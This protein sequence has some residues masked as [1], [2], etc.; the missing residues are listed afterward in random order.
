V[1]LFAA[2]WWLSARPRPRGA[3]SG[4]FLI[5]YGLVRFVVEY[6][7]EPDHFLG[8]L[9]L[10]LS[11]GQWLSAPMVLLGAGMMLWAYRAP[12]TEATAAKRR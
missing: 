6:T 4:A 8:V 7:R 11:M 1:A 2:L 12:K 5:G 10:G 3:V 9:S